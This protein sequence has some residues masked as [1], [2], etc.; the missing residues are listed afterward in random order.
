[1][2]NKF[3]I[4]ALSVLGLGLLI[5]LTANFNKGSAIGGTKLKDPDKA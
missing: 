4:I 5:S 3:A 2:K 1:M